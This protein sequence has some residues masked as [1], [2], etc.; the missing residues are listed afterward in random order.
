ML[1]SYFSFRDNKVVP[2]WT[3]CADAPIAAA[4]VR[5]E[6]LH[7]PLPGSAVLPF[8]IQSYLV[9]VILDLEKNP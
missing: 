5:P 2:E 3:A 1:K 9:Q 7:H 4:A 8:Q 6:R